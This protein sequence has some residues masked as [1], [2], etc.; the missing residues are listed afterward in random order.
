MPIEYKT[1]ECSNPQDRTEK[2]FYALAQ[3]TGDTRMDELCDEI[4]QISA[5]S[6]SDVYGVLYALLEVLP[7]HLTNGRSVHLEGLG[8]F[9][10]SLR[11]STEDSEDDV[12][13]H[14]IKGARVLFT[15]GKDL[16]KALSNL[17]YRK[18]Q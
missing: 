4:V 9:R 14:S 8:S 11:S 16:K 6:K 12:D 5:L 15:T 1:L 3:K 2:K 13:V 18:V 7:R 10:I 17:K